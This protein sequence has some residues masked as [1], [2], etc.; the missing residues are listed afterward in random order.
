MQRAIKSLCRFPLSIG[1]AEFRY[2]STVAV[3]IFFN[4]QF[5]HCLVCGPRFLLSLVPFFTIYVWFDFNS[6]RIIDLNIYMFL[7]GVGPPS[8]CIRILHLKHA[9]T[10]M[11]CRCHFAIY[12]FF[13]SFFLFIPRSFFWDATMAIDLIKCFFHYLF[14]HDC[15]WRKWHCV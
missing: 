13:S 9:I 5:S 15:G 4:S 1:A 12:F 10:T 2:D 3:T 7:C 11:Y 14:A 6:N 8:V